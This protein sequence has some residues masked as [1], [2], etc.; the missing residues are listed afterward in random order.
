MSFQAI[1]SSPAAHGSVAVRFI[2]AEDPAWSDLIS[3][4]PHDFFQLPGYTRLAARQ[5]GCQGVAA[6]ISS[7][8][9]ALLIPLLIHP[10]DS[11]CGWFD[12]CS[13]YGYPGMVLVDPQRLDVLPAFAEA[14][15]EQA[16]RQRIVSVFIRLHPLLGPAAEALDCFGAVV[17]H[18][19]VV[20]VDL[21]DGYDQA[22]RNMRRNHRQDIAVLRRRGFT[23]LVNDWTRL[24]DFIAVYRQTMLRKG[25]DSRLFFDEEYFASLAALG[26]DD[27][28]ILFIVLAPDRQI[29]SGALLTA[30]GQTAS[31][32]LGG[33]SA[34]HLDMAPSKLVYDEMIRWAVEHGCRQLLLGGGLGA[35]ED[36]LYHFKKGFSSA[37]SPFFTLRMVTARERFNE[38]AAK[39]NSRGQFAAGF[40]EPLFFPPYRATSH[41]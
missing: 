37:T 13:P 26:R 11:V 23:C 15:Y 33:S 2:S 14:F 17:S 16:R 21:S 38:L 34:R 22:L 28:V 36:S 4:S 3:R 7:Q 5:E 19:R 25:A 40:A 8:D 1:N 10:Q 20:Y 41:G 31:F 18:G 35:R 30:T 39:R 32:F 29:A 12:A 6:L 24:D 9:N 27:K